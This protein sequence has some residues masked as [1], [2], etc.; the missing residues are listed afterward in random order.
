MCRNGVG[1]RVTASSGGHREAVSSTATK[2]MSENGVTGRHGEASRAN[3]LPLHG[4]Q[5][6]ENNRLS[7]STLSSR[8]GAVSHVSSELERMIRAICREE[9]LK[10]GKFHVHD[11]KENVVYKQV[12]NMMKDCQVQKVDNMDE[13]RNVDVPENRESRTGT[14]K[15]YSPDKVDSSKRAEV[16]VEQDNERIVKKNKVYSNAI[17]VENDEEF[18]WYAEGLNKRVQQSNGKNRRAT[19]EHGKDEMNVPA[20][21][22]FG[23]DSVSAQLLLDKG[24]QRSFVS[25][26]LYN[27]KLVGRTNKYRSFVRMY[28]VGGQELATSGEVELDI[29]IGDDIVRQKFIIADIKEEGI[30]GFDFCKNHQ[31]EWRWKDNQLKLGGELETDDSSSI[32][33]RV[34]RITLKQLTVT[35]SK[36]EIVTSGILEHAKDCE[37]MGLIQPQSHFLET[38]QI[39]VAAVLA[40]ER[41]KQCAYAIDKHTRSNSNPSQEHSG[42][43]VCTGGHIAVF[44]WMP[45]IDI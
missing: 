36:S 37:E 4:L 24:A 39:G 20:Q 16:D 12:R 2:G 25:Q 31:A 7:K 17:D 3:S 34:A 11:E 33:G 40:R 21:M 8:F 10:Y 29:Q 5:K 18:R 45:F 42:S 6:D 19:L 32:P 28:G 22:L 41:R 30:L 44:Y 43:Y 9:L 38:H 14:T 26:K 13:T 35:P 23:E 27:D 15:C 1:K